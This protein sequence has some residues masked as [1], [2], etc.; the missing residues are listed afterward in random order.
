MKTPPQPIAMV[1]TNQRYLISH[2]SQVSLHRVGI[3][4]IGIVFWLYFTYP[5]KSNE[6]VTDYL[7]TDGQYDCTYWYLGIAQGKPVNQ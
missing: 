3:L 2:V 1:T 7:N 6:Q 4:P 5:V